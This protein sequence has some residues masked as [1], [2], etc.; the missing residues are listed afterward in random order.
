MFAEVMRTARSEQKHR[1]GN[2]LGPNASR[3]FHELKKWLNGQ[4]EN[5]IS[6]IEGAMRAGVFE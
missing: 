6:S 5:V 4:G 1:P 3:A 2:E